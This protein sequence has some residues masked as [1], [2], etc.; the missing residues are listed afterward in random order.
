MNAIIRKHDHILQNNTVL[1]EPFPSHSITVANKRGNNL[2]QLIARPDPYN[3]K[4]EF[5]DQTAHAYKK[6]GRKCDS[7]DNFVLEETSFMCFPTGTKFRICRDSTC[8][9]KNVIYLANF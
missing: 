2:H 5:L 1:K 6:C 4:T 7:C 8:N 9:T 3:I